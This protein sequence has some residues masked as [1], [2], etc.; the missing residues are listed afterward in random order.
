MRSETDGLFA[1]KKIKVKTLNMETQ[2]V[3]HSRHKIGLRLINLLSGSRE[4]SIKLNKI[5]EISREAN[6]VS[7]ILLF[8]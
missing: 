5:T 1:Q 8:T 4:I 3:Q 6:F 2:M 7:L